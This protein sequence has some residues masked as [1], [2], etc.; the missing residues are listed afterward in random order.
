MKAKKIG[1]SLKSR[2]VNFFNLFTKELHSIEFKQTVPVIDQRGAQKKNKSNTVYI[3]PFIEEHEVN[4]IDKKHPAIISSESE[5]SS[6]LIAANIFEEKPYRLIQKHKINYSSSKELI[7]GISKKLI[8][9]RTKLDNESNLDDS[10]KEEFK[11]WKKENKSL[12]SY[13]TNI[14]HFNLK[15]YDGINITDPIE[16][17]WL[18]QFFVEEDN[19]EEFRNALSYFEY[20]DKIIIENKFSNKTLKAGKGEKISEKDKKPFTYE[21]LS[22]WGFF[23]NDKIYKF[24]LMQRKYSWDSHLVKQFFEDIYNSDIKPHYMGNVLIKWNEK[25][26]VWDILDG[27]QRV[28]TMTLILSSIFFAFAAFKGFKNFIMPEELIELFRAPKNKLHNKFAKIKSSSDFQSFFDITNG[29]EENIKIVEGLLKNTTSSNFDN[30]KEQFKNIF[31]FID[32][33]IKDENGERDPKILKKI[34]KNLLNNIYISFLVNNEEDEFEMFEKLNTTSKPLTPI[35]LLRNSL[36]SLVEE[37]ERDKEEQALTTSFNG[38]EKMFEDKNG[39]IQDSLVN[40]FMQY[41]STLYQVEK[42]LEFKAF[43][44]TVKKAFGF[45]KNMKYGTFNSKID[46]LKREIK[47]FKEI[48]IWDNFSNNKSK[49]RNI[50]DILIPIHSK[51]VYVPL[52]KYIISEGRGIE[53]TSLENLTSPKIKSKREILKVIEKYEIYT[54][55]VNFKGASLRKV[56]GKII[57]KLGTEGIEKNI[58]LKSFNDIDIVGGNNLMPNDSEFENKLRDAKLS[59]KVG[60]SIINRVEFELNNIGKKTLETSSLIDDPTLEHIIP[61]N[62][63]NWH[64]HL[65]DGSKYKTENEVNKD[66]QQIMPTIGNFLMIKKNLNS[67]IN[68]TDPKS[69]QKSYEEYPS[70]SSLHLFKGTKYTTSEKKEIKLNKLDAGNIHFSDIEERS[71]SIAEIA[72]DIYKKI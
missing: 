17:R 6:A 31:I 37:S 4:S 54:R 43:R 39:K 9:T 56:V 2:Y 20:G 28:I 25:Q 68:N 36:F 27:Q 22:T 1:T 38:V 29:E 24:P 55:V 71:K 8:D 72:K 59:N 48:H 26:K 50:R 41:L 58:L 23:S 44:E 3:S 64:K 12:I 47:F 33:Y 21:V 19:E 62:I 35:D 60:L 45:E 51:D 16:K 52:I 65:I 10:E 11:F 46:L 67:K 70:I 34:T 18:L 5:V 61:Q 40:K 53:T 32:E 69:K 30:I 15:H 7:P 42:G 14:T 13:L 57:S 63:E 66:F 49:L